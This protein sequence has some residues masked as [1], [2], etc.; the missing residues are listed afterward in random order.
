MA[1]GYRQKILLIR[2]PVEDFR[3]QTIESRYVLVL[4][5]SE[6][7]EN[8]DASIHLRGLRNQGLWQ[9]PMAPIKI[10]TASH[11]LRS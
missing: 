11:K 4:A 6:I 8:T 5:S 7:N 10:E 2:P 3:F 1:G 9:I